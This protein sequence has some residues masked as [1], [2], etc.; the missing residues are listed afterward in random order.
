MT[1]VIALLMFLGE[2]AVLKEHTLMPNISKCLELKRIATR[3]SGIR[4]SY[5]CSKVKAEVKDGK[6]IRIA[7]DN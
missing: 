7:K 1:S 4:V 2:P 6:I 5:V 3:N